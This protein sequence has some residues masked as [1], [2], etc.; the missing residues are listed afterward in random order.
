MTHADPLFDEAL[1][2]ATKG[3]HDWLVWKDRSGQTQIGKTSAAT[4]KAAML[5]TGTQRWFTL[6]AANSGH[7]YRITWRL[8]VLHLRNGRHHGFP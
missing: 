4:Y 7:L 2:K 6:I 8:A 5:A 3:H 1:R